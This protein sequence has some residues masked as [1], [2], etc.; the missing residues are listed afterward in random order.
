MPKC[1]IVESI[2]SALEEKIKSLSEALS[3]DPIY[4]AKVILCSG[5]D[6]DGKALYN[7]WSEEFGKKMVAISSAISS[8][9]EMIK[10]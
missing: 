8:L 1:K 5:M 10:E 9:Y 2:D 4:A 7:K 3:K 6:W